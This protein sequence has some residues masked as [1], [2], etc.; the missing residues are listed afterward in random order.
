MAAFPR[1]PPTG[2]RFNGPEQGARYAAAAL[3]TVA[4]EVARQSLREATAMA[5]PRL[6]RRFR[7]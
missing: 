1:V 5:A 3:S 7:G 6:R 2:N 4:A